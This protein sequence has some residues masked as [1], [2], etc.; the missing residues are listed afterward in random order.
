VPGLTWE[1]LGFRSDVPELMA[2]SHVLV[3]PSSAEGLPQV[4]VQAAAVQLPFVSYAVDG[5]DE[6][7]GMGAAGRKVELG[8]PRAM[9]DAV[10]GIVAGG[11][12]ARTGVDFS[13][14]DQAKVLWAYRQLYQRL[15]DPIG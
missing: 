4:L 2:G 10:A 1:L 9:G 13:S 14:W 3:L 8:N 6:L 11:S 7:I 5:V 15:M 12:R